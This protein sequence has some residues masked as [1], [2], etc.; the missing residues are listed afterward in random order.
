LMTFF[1]C[2]AM[3]AFFTLCR[4]YIQGG[5]L[6]LFH[7][8]QVLGR[9]L[10]YGG[11]VTVSSIAGPLL[12]YADRFAVGTLLSIAAVAYYTGPADMVNRA[13]VIP[14][15][16]ASTLFP[17]FSSLE[18]A[19]AREKLQDIYGR[20]LKYLVVA[21]GPMLLLVATF[22]RD[23]LYVWLGPVFAQQGTLPLQI[24]AA[25]VLINSFGIIP[26]SL[27]QGVGRPDITAL[28]HVLEV[29]LHLGLMWILVLKMGI[30]G[31]A[32]AV[33][34]RLLIDTMLVVG[35]CSRLGFA[36]L[37]AIHEKGVTKSILGLVF[38][39]VV[40]LTPSFQH[41]ALLNRVIMA[42][43]LFVFYLGAQWYWV[44]DRR[45]RQF[46]VSTVERL[47]M[48]LKIFQGHGPERYQ[49]VHVTHSPERE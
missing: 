37:R 34:A 40:L 31:A 45:D 15:S 13:L 16:L 33:T 28:F 44:F 12:I 14:A 47:G 38:I 26:F 17:A 43:I 1:R 2:L 20:S 30:T 7:Q 27:L 32:I 5:G 39:G 42:G 41:R 21:M 11:W 49:L 48:T 6:R 25:G 46:L 8:R 24:L 23:I 3:L 29:P 4:P 19:G 9:L 36:S 35:A 22:S 18:A 10:K